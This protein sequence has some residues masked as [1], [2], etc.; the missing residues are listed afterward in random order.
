MKRA[1]LGLLIALLAIAGCKPRQPR[2]NG[3]AGLDVRPMPTSLE[4][5]PPIRRMPAT[6]KARLVGNID[7]KALGPF[8]ARSP[9]GG[10]I[11]WIV[12]ADRGGGQDLMFVPTGTDGAAL[13]EPRKLT[14]VPQEATQLFVRPAGGTHGGWML[15]WSALLDRGESL[16]VTGLALDGTSRTK[17]SDLQRTNDHVK[18]ADLVAGPKGTVAVWAEET[19][20][21]D[22]NMLAAPIDADGRPRGMP[23]RVARGVIGWAAVTAGDGAGLALV[24]PSNEPKNDAGRLAWARLD[25][26]G[27]PD[28]PAVA[29]GT[30]ATVSGDVDVVATPGGW[31]LAWTDRTGEDATVMLAT[32]DAAG[33]VRGPRP[34]MNAVG[35]TSLVALASGPAGVALAWQEPRGRARDMR[36]LHL[37][38]V[39]T[40]GD[41]VAQPVS[42]VEIASRATPELVATPDGFALLASTR[43]CLGGIPEAGCEQTV[44][45]TVVKLDARLVPSQTEPFYVG[46]PR[47]EATLG[48]GLRCVGER[49]VAL[50]ASGDTPTGVYT[51]DVEPRT[52]PY[53]SPAIAPPPPE[54]ARVTGVET[55]ASGLPYIDVATATS[56]DSTLVATLTTPVDAPPKN[57]KLKG[58]AAVI[59]VRPV[60]AQGA[61]LGPSMVVTQRAQPAGG[62]AIAAGGRPEDGAVVVWV[63]RDDGDLQVHVGHVDRHGKRTQEM[64][65]TSTKG[66]ASDVAAAWTGDGWLIAWVDMRDG[67]GEVYASKVDR[68]LNR[69]AREERITHAPGDAG[70]VALVVKGDTAWVAWS[71]P[72]ESPREGMADIFTTTLHTRD[73]KRAGDE[74]RVLATAAHS[75]SPQL[76]LAG[77]GALV[78]WIEEGPTGLDAPAAGMVARLD[79]AGHVVGPPGVIPMAGRGRATSLALAPAADGV[80]AIVARS[81][82]D[83]V[84][85]DAVGLAPDGTAGHPWP[86]LDLDAPGTFEVALAL[87]G[88]T[89]YFD[90]IGRTLA[91]HRVRRAALSWGH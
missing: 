5:L 29:I 35:G 2:P 22:A 27:R 12:A 6:A 47:H 36:P 18:W 34:A 80:H 20:A 1:S 45:P 32:V 52:S 57:D 81:D 17:P 88:E 44:V 14:D 42:A 30:R 75:R 77:D 67:N 72:R 62:L 84:T 19:P 71:D 59:S 54:A 43:T 68:D 25:S 49:C 50:A 90:D 46:E 23:V 24:T 41:P 3:T 26:E 10:L 63:A 13:R 48:W 74:V 85:L 21:G 15:A 66:D 38:S 8:T 73:A 65:L 40:R 76:A 87:S 91:G 58:R 82:R 78:A 79:G 7:H 37:A 39:D 31:L 83:D 89:L 70:D 28:G 9:E 60:D 33:K 86:L 55:V 69:M 56:G 64:Q 11:A 4:R 16:T 51:V 61:E 53:A